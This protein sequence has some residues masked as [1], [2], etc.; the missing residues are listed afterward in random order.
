MKGTRFL[1]L[2]F[3]L[4]AGMGQIIRAEAQTDSQDNKIVVTGTVF[5]SAKR[6]VIYYKMGFQQK[7][8]QS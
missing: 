1:F 2:I 3:L 8:I 4:L 6:Q 5:D 7:K